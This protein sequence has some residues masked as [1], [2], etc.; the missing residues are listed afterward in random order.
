MAATAGRVNIAGVVCYRTGHRSRFF[1]ELHIWHRRRGE[2]KVFAWRPYRDLIVM[3]HLQLGTPVVGSW[4]SLN[5]HLVKELAD[6]AEEHKDWLG[7]VTYLPDA[8]L[9]TGVESHRGDLVATHAAP[10]RIR[11]GRPRPS[12]PRDQTKAEEDPVPAPPDRR[13][14]A[15]R[16]DRRRRRDETTGRRE[17]NLYCLRRGWS[18][19]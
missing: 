16:L 14:P 17:F 9:C 2:P 7:L 11:C 6:F 10:G 4:D 18:A 3:T 5:V 12:D 15:P 1:F 19:T 8:F 13:V